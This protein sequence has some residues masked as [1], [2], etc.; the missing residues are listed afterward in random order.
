MKQVMCSPRTA[1]FQFF[2]AI[3]AGFLMSAVVQAAPLTD[4]Q[5]RSLLAAQEEFQ[6]L[7]GEFPELERKE[8]EL[9]YDPAHPVSSILPVLRD[10]PEAK[11]RIE[12]I[13]RKHGFDNLEHYAEIGDRVYVSVMAIGMRD[14]SPEEKK[15]YE[16]MANA[17][18]GDDAPDY[19][20][21]QVQKM[22]EQRKRME[23][24][25]ESASDEDIAA[26]RPFMDQLSP[27]DDR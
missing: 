5:I 4:D 10:L 16:E 25:V 1:P 14:M 22:Q 21:A 17:H 26:V 23:T 2:L 6:S 3:I 13:V 11:R 27:R 18:V 20:K 24:A 15:M 7:D 19:M 8:E 9:E 12:G